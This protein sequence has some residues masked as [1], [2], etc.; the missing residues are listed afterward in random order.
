MLIIDCDAPNG[1]ERAVQ[2]G[3]MS[4]DGVLVTNPKIPQSGGGR[5]V[6]LD[7]LLIT[8]QFIAAI[9]AKAPLPAGPTEGE[10]S[11]SLNGGV[12]IAGERA[13]FHGKKDALV[14]ARNGAQVAAEYL[15]GKGALRHFVNAFLAVD[16]R[17]LRMTAGA[18]TL[19]DITVCLPSELPAALSTLTGK[20]RGNVTLDS[21]YRILEALDLG[22]KLPTRDKIAAQGFRDIPERSST[23]TR[24]ARSRPSAGPSSRR[25]TD[26]RGAVLRF[27]NSQSQ[28]VPAPP[29]PERVVTRTPAPEEPWTVGR[30]LLALV[31]VALVAVLVVALGRSAWSWFQGHGEFKDY[32][33]AQLASSELVIGQELRAAEDLELD[34]IKCYDIGDGGRRC[35]ADIV[36]TLDGEP[37]RDLGVFAETPL[38]GG[39]FNVFRFTDDRPPVPLTGAAAQSAEQFLNAAERECARRLGGPVQLLPVETEGS[40]GAYGAPLAARVWTNEFNR[41]ICAAAINTDGGP[42]QMRVDVRSLVDEEQTSSEG[43]LILSARDVYL[44]GDNYVGVEASRDE[45]SQW[46]VTY[47]PDCP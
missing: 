8:P 37:I 38:D 47:G 25:S 39:D 26:S 40:D 28:P 1:P 4:L 2:R 30:A 36:G 12:T 9:E 43:K 19:G 27:P 33:T 22:S 15:R 24:G 23:S 10:L 41:G 7:G 31:V 29:E 18:V 14:Q 42:V 20:Q 46:T 34:D 6:E 11:A 45:S 21:A 13:V 16:G 32:A 3:L 44:C 17:G 35:V 5:L